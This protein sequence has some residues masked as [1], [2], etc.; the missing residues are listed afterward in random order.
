MK[1]GIKIVAVFFT[2][3]IL[4]TVCMA[5]NMESDAVA[6]RGN[7]SEAVIENEQ[8]KITVSLTNGTYSAIR[9]KDG[10]ECIS[11][12]FWSVDD[13]ISTDGY[14]FKW[15]QNSLSDRLGEGKELLLT[16][17]KIGA[18]SLIIGLVL[19]EK[20]GFIAVHNGIV[21][22][23]K[24]VL[25][26]KTFSP[27][28]GMAYR[29]SKFKD[30]ML[31]DGESGEY[32]TKVL[33]GDDAKALS[34]FN[35]IL[36]T[37][38]DKGAT[39]SNL[40]IGGLSYYE[41]MKHA[42]VKRLDDTL[43][44]NLWSSDPVGKRVDSGSIYVFDKDRFYI[45]FVTPSRFEILETYA[46]A[47]KGANN[48][49]LDDMTAPG[50]NFW[51]CQQKK[52]GG[53]EFKNTSVGTLDA[54]QKAKNTGF[55]NYGPLAVRLEP[56]DY[57]KPNNQQGWWDDEHFQMYKSGKLEQPYETIEKW[58]DA[59]S[60][61]GGIPLIYLQ[62]ARRS[63]DYAE[64]FPEHMLFNDSNKERSG[65]KLNYGIGGTLWS[66]DFTDDG[67][68][69]HMQD[70]YQNFKNGGLRGVKFDYPDTG[71]AYDGG[72]EDL[73][74][75]TTSAYR[76]IYQLAY[77][78]LGW[79]SDIHERLPLHGD[80]CL[81]VITTHRTEGDT[82]RFY[83]VMARKCGLRWYKNRVVTKYVNDVINPFHAFPLNN[84][85]WRTMYTM[86]YLTNGRIELGKYIEKMT[87]EMRHDLTRVVP[88][89][90][91]KKSARPVDAFSGGEY[92]QIFDFE[93]NPSWHQVAFFN[94]QIEKDSMTV[95][96]Q[97]NSIAR[98]KEN[99]DIKR[100]SHRVKPLTEWPED[101]Y[102]LWKA[103]GT[104]PIAST[105]SVSLSDSQDDGGLGLDS[106][107]E[108]YAYDFWNDTFIGKLKG[109]SFL[110][111][112][113]RPG[114]TRMMSI[115]KVEPNPQFISTDRHVMQGF[116]DFEKV[117]EWDASKNMLSGISK[118]IM[119]ETYTVVLALNGY[120]IKDCTVEGADI[121]YSNVDKNI[122]KLKVLAKE[123]TSV[124]WNIYF[125]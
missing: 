43:E 123:N 1:A 124:E 67:F 12:A 6:I 13:W 11:E 23:Q 39:K 15:K 25:Q 5:I 65:G 37:F 116:V 47:L 54:L 96:A 61:N 59:V 86:S 77:D 62:T 94:T 111:Q 82:D 112:E 85:G 97:W 115:H 89:Y 83:P 22:T 45:D 34:S 84:D 81:G 30:F 41:F 79:N 49:K 55:L 91:M 17:T 8:I 108:Y 103:G 119:D 60:E 3:F 2:S 70:V 114:E 36:A 27:L 32:N 28:S 18:P 121:T 33:K 101:R 56:D 4:S 76:S 71:W 72:M 14:S 105:V 80:I 74:A 68:I 16:G 106:K 9:K 117:P 38:G 42:K 73:Y 98:E 102:G 19:Y 24:E 122:C 58:G 113:L 87:N 78:G 99:K 52:W 46:Q 48:V 40:V 93:I 29:G 53:D 120:T 63:L 66:Y 57:A 64:T 44:I 118:V 92:P 88:L 20:E 69:A 104:L 7:T 31:L 10:F 90:T 110:K 95:K 107:S 51:Y 75:T 109:N 35:N 50:L 26:V 100:E 125:K 21:N